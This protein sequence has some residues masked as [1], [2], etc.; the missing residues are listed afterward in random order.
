MSWEIT[1]S[2]DFCFGHRV[3][4]QKLNPELSCNS[5]CKCRHQHGHQGLI[6]ISLSGSELNNAGMVLDFV[7]LSWFKKWLDAVL[8]HKMILDYLDPS[9]PIFYPLFDNR[10]D[11]DNI[12]F[13]QIFEHFKEGYMLVKSEM[14]GTLSSTEQEIY[15]GLVLVPFVPT[16]ENLSK[17]LFDIVQKKLEGYATV[18]KIEFY[19]TPKSCSTYYGS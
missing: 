9:L 11:E 19:E 8:D 6:N 1:K 7:E 3:W 12:N 10:D 5:S 17:W 14:Y 2:F 16:S 13:D 15:G 4:T 18:S